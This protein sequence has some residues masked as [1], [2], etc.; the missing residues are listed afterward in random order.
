[1]KLDML[2]AGEPK[3]ASWH[4][5]GHA[6]L[7]AHQAHHTQQAHTHTLTR[8][9]THTHFCSPGTPHTASARSHAQVAVPELGSLEIPGLRLV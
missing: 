5:R 7:G 2:G 4:A 1:M 9:T 8:H 6:R 3:E